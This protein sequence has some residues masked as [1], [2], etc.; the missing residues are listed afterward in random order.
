[1]ERPGHVAE[2]AI[3]WKEKI[4]PTLSLTKTTTPLPKCQL[5]TRVP[6][7]GF[8]GS[9][10]IWPEDP[11]LRSSNVD[12]TQQFR[13]FDDTFETS[14]KPPR[15]GSG[16]QHRSSG[17]NAGPLRKQSG[18]S[19]GGRGSRRAA[20]GVGGSGH[21][22]GIAKISHRRRASGNNCGRIVT[23]R[24]GGS[25]ALPCGAETQGA[26]FR[27]DSPSDVDDCGITSSL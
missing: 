21:Y 23:A 20:I 18:C 6:D 19:S 5:A 3:K 1:L 27:T 10:L 17:H 16:P 4:A 2:E 11:I 26:G 22:N 14:A 9:V 12:E 7:R 8:L 24:L 15:R 13:D 25:L